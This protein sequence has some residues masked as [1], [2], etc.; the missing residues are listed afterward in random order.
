MSERKLPAGMNWDKFRQMLENKG[1]RESTIQKYE[2]YARLLDGIPIDNHE[3]INDWLMNPNIPLSVKYGVSVVV[4]GY[5][6]KILKFDPNLIEAVYYKSK[7]C[8]FFMTEKEMKILLNE[9]KSDPKDN[10]FYM[11]VKLMFNA[12]SRVGILLYITRGMFDYDN[13]GFNIPESIYGNKQKKKF[14]MPIVRPDFAKEF[15]LYL[16]TNKSRNRI[17]SVKR[18]LPEKIHSKWLHELDD[19]IDIKYIQKIEVKLTEKLKKYARRIKNK[20]QNQKNIDRWTEVAK[21]ISN[22]KI[23]HSYGTDYRVKGGK[24]FH[25]QGNMGHKSSVSSERYGHTVMEEQ[26]KDVRRVYGE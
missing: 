3:E 19:E 15:K 7:E 16:A 8:E 10:H 1:R 21:R 17:F 25:L 4:R 12:G 9:I 11:F 2:E 24:L 22:H 5:Y 20:Q 23:R 18:L 14:F 13:S 6:N 26:I